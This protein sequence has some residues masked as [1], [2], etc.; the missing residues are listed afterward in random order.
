MVTAIL[1]WSESSVTAGWN[2]S[3]QHSRL[4]CYFQ[5]TG[6]VMVEGQIARQCCFLNQTEIQYRQPGNQIVYYWK[7]A[8]LHCQ[9]KWI[10]SNCNVCA[11]GWSGSN[12][13]TCTLGWTGDDCDTCADGLLPPTCDQIC[14]GFGCCNHGTYQGCIQNG[15]WE[16]SI[17]AGSLEVHLMFRG[18]TCWSQV[19][20]KGFFPITLYLSMLLL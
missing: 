13:D 16:G 6:M 10:G 15:R 17:E 20:F 1:I 18:E 2:E 4:F 7:L 11:L 8:D 9:D 14:D 12:C 19:G 5:C 3:V